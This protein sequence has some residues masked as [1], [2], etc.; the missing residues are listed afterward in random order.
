MKQ[1]LIL[2]TLILFLSLKTISGQGFL[3][4][5]GK[6][7]VD[8][9]GKVVMLRGIGLGGWMLQ[10]PYMLQ[11][12]KVAGAQYEIREKIS[13]LIGEKNTE[14][15]YSAY[16]QNMIRKRDID[17]LK[18]WGFN[19]IRLPM[20]YNL[21]T[22]PIEKE[23]VAGGNTWLETGF[24]LT[25]S[26][27]SWCKENRIYLILDLHAAPGGQGKDRPI[28]DVDTTKPRLWESEAN[29]HKTIELWAKLAARYSQEE[30]IGGYDLINETNWNMEG[31]EPLKH[32]FLELTTE[33]RK[34]DKNHIIFIEGN[35]FA[36]DFTGLLPQWDNNLAYSFH[37]Y[38]NPTTLETIQRFIDISE[39]YTV[40]LWMGESGENTNDWY[41]AAVTLLESNN[42]GW[43]WWTIKKLGSESGLMNVQ[44]PV[45]YQKIIDYWSGKGTRP[46]GEEALKI[47]MELAENMKLEKCRINYGVV[48]ALF[49]K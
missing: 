33:I 9:N 17:S 39:K 27:L 36:N 2:I 47:F 38:W 24:A 25:D 32:L 3:K 13:E 20:H 15:F 26:L 49:G 35:Q 44:I 18:V 28:A 45:D 34:V 31:N 10:E 23:P 16:R 6:Q 37:K 1:T 46:S 22:L 48:K 12:S 8:G 7:I 43:A 29:Q 41:R 40:P 11:L 19:S 42:V 30:W 4:V 14:K 21:F 5:N